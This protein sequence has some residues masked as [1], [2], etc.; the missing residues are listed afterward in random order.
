MFIAHKLKIFKPCAEFEVSAMLLFPVVF[1]TDMIQL[2]HANVIDVKILSP[3]QSII[4]SGM[5]LS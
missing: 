5:P 1:C 2:L 4:A 3:I